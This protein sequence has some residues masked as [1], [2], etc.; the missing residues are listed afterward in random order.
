MP[1][2][3]YPS[4]R[5]GL[6][7]C[8]VP[9]LGASGLSLIDRSGRGNHGVL[10][11]MGSQVNW[12]ASGGALALNFD[13]VN[14]YVETVRNTGLVGNISLSLAGWFRIPT[15]AATGG[16]FA[17]GD[18]A[19][20]AAACGIYFAVRSAN[21]ISIEFA[22]NTPA[23]TTAQ[24]A[25]DSWTHICCTK[26]PGA[27]AATTSIF[28]NGVSV[29]A[30]TGSTTT[31]SLVDVTVRIGSFDYV[32]YD[33]T[34]MI[35]DDLRIYNRVLTPAEIRLLASRRGIGLTPLP[36]RGGG[37]PRKLSVNV[38]G[39]WRAAD[40]YINVGGTWKIGQAS[41]NVAGVWK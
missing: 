3:E 8:W 20:T 36:D 16:L 40:S 14:D 27:A 11:N 35:S 1:R 30:L 28:Y 6:V 41:V 9:S 5:Q 24:I 29:G 32:A 10:K 19:Q 37:L 18:S 23:Q 34:Q 4:L 39:T 7:G 17:I 22:G 31:P 38:G 33:G 15:G 13:G 25:R 12:R 2:Q 21:A 26:T